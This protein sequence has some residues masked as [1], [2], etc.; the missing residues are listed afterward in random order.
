MSSVIFCFELVEW[1]VGVAGGA[2]ECVG[3]ECD[4]AAG[5]IGAGVG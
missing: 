5:V 1:V 4:E 2:E 3:L